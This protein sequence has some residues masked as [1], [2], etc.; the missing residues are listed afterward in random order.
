MVKIAGVFF[1]SGSFSFTFV[2]FHFFY[3]TGSL[4]WVILISLP[5][6]LFSQGLDLKKSCT[7]PNFV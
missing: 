4:H 2:P 7:Y 3:E 1:V 5:L 6:K